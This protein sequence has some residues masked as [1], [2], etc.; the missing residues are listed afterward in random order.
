M[1]IRRVI[2]LSSTILFLTLIAGFGWIIRSH[3]EGG[4]S[5][6]KTGY[7]NGVDAFAK[8]SAEAW[9]MRL[10]TLA[11]SVGE[12]ENIGELYVMSRRSSRDLG[13][14]NSELMDVCAR[15]KCSFAQVVSVSPFKRKTHKAFKDEL[16]LKAEEG[17]V[18]GDIAPVYGMPMAIGYAPILIQKEV[19]AVLIIAKVLN[20]EVASSVSKA[21][22]AHVRYDENAGKVFPVVSSTF[23]QELTH[24]ILWRVVVYG[25]GIL[26]VAMVLLNLGLG[27]LFVNK[28]AALLNEI[29]NT[30]IELESGRVDVPSPKRFAIKE[31]TQLSAVFHRVG[32]GLEAFQSQVATKSR[33]E[34]I[35]DKAAQVAHD[36]V[37]PVAALA[38]SL[39]HEEF[40]ELSTEFRANVERTIDR[41]RA[42]ATS[43]R[44]DPGKQSPLT[45]A[46]TPQPANVAWLVDSI[47]AEKSTL[48][49]MNISL[50]VEASQF[51]SHATFANVEEH[52]FS[53]V[54]SN[55]IQNA[56]EA[57]GSEVGSVSI[58][59]L[60]GESLVRIEIE[61]T[62]P[63][64]HPNDLPRIGQRGVS[65]GKANGS[66]LGLSNAIDEVRKWG[67]RLEIGSHVGIGTTITIE[68][69]STP[70][71]SWQLSE[72][73]VSNAEPIIVIDDDQS[74]IEFW[75][76][77]F[78]NLKLR[79]EYYSSAEEFLRKCD[80]D[81]DQCLVLCD[82][83]LGGG[84]NGLQLIEQLEF[85]SR[86]IL[87]TGK[88][89]DRNIQKQCSE[90]NCKLLGK[91]NLDAVAIRVIPKRGR[92]A[93]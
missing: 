84:W 8:S 71:P 23:V 67:G 19:I 40:K 64:I 17:V 83:D 73:V 55:L 15:A 91:H 93:E 37:S 56:I 22:L 69:P 41:I 2:L 78:E 24:S 6:L 5:Q 85:H 25:I 75:K 12:Q 54:I 53:R 51:D 50:L 82:F 52:S 4:F 89:F 68:L 88:S 48:I 7:E 27:R 76:A 62:G 66:G 21:T 30:G 3:L 31:L 57:I 80:L 1:T 38:A 59:L 9:A 47:V 60:N 20:G 81:I 58:R 32:K 49:D 77:R 74:M 70:A 45:S 42:I 63:G 90:L 14:L 65:L 11:Q 43:L 72:I 33:S 26:S 18:T 87:V 34:A 86:A 92:R 36:L 39:E 10:A 13:A 46:E 44:G 28:F 29:S 16:I 61:D 35:G 79:I